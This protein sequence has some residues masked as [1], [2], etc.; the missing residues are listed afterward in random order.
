MAIASSAEE[1]TKQHDFVSGKALAF[2]FYFFRSLLPI[3]MTLWSFRIQSLL[4]IIVI[5]VHKT[6]IDFVSV[7]DIEKFLTFFEPNIDRNGLRRRQAD[8]ECVAPTWTNRVHIPVEANELY[9]RTL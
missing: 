5:Y 2:D 3:A 4:I 7:Q 8:G 9:F 6:I 1:P